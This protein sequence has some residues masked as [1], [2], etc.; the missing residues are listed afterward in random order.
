MEVNSFAENRHLEVL[1]QKGK[2]GEKTPHLYPTR[3]R[4]R[5]SRAFWNTRLCWPDLSV[6][7]QSRLLERSRRCGDTVPC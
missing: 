7:G 2:E 5:G 6:W 3:N 4:G 1:R